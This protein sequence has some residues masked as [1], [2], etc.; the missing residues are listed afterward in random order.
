LNVAAHFHAE[1]L[2]DGRRTAVLIPAT[3]NDRIRL[4]PD[5]ARQR[6]DTIPVGTKVYEVL[7]FGFEFSQ[8]GATLT[9]RSLRTGQ[10]YAL[11][12]TGVHLVNC[13]ELTPD[14]LIELGHASRASFDG[15]FGL[16]LGDRPAWFIRLIPLSTTA[17]PL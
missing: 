12:V 15:E 16:A 14:E 8:V 3:P 9:M 1:E 10:H 13:D 17:H 5:G 4:A 2:L 11:T 7:H 6:L